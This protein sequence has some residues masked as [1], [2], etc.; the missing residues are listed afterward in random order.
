MEGEGGAILEIEGRQCPLVDNQL[1]VQLMDLTSATICPHVS[2][3]HS[4]ANFCFTK[5]ER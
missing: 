5:R 3:R 1:Q 2:F 4:R